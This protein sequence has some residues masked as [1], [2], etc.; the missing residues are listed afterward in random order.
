[1]SSFYFK[2]LLFH[3][4]ECFNEYWIS[5]VC[6]LIKLDLFETGRNSDCFSWLQLELKVYY[7]ERK[8][9][10][11]KS[12]LDSAPFNFAHACCYLST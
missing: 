6:L 2:L 7:D 4:L 12:L 1:M 11:E 10:N 3:T 5:L 9:L 8:K